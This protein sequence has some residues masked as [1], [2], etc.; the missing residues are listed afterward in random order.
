MYTCCQQTP[1]SHAVNLG[2]SLQAVLKYPGMRHSRS[3]LARPSGVPKLLEMEGE[4]D[5]W[6]SNTNKMTFGKAL[7]LA[8]GFLCLV[9][10]Q[11]PPSL[12]C[13]A[14]CMWLH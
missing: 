12:T 10:K 2:K 5:M 4:Q 1:A 3:G 14:H 9:W 11:P 7:R 13:L 8:L 6:R